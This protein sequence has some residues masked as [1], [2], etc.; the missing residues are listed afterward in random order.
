MFHGFNKDKIELPHIDILFEKS[1][2]P[3]LENEIIR[4][5]KKVLTNSI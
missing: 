1:L 3:E 4:I 2:P 5:G